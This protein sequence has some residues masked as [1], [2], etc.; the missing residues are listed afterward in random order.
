MLLQTTINRFL[1]SVSILLFLVVMN[2]LLVSMSFSLNH[3][4]NCS[5]RTL[6]KR[7]FIHMR[8][9]KH[10]PSKSGFCD[11]NCHLSRVSVDIPWPQMVMAGYS[12]DAIGRAVV[13]QILIVIL[14]CPLLSSFF[15]LIK[16]DYDIAMSS[17]IFFFE[18]IKIM[19]DLFALPHCW[20]WN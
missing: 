20:Q 6:V 13:C 10:S 2:L 5:S 8:E 16:I 7:D 9:I 3:E 1:H 18:L 4:L 12:R 11:Q 14:Q 15:K 19:P 17:F